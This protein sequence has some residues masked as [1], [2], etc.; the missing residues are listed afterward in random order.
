MTSRF[1]TKVGLFVVTFSAQSRM[2]LLP[3]VLLLPQSSMFTS[4][5]RNRAVH[6]LGAQVVVTVPVLL[7]FW[8]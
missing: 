4:H 6:I 8:T 2:F 5:S 3:E 1:Q 7:T